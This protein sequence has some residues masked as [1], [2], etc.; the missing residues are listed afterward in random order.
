MF[1][2]CHNRFLLNVYDVETVI[3]THGVSTWHK[4]YGWQWKICDALA[5]PSDSIQLDEL[6]LRQELCEVHIFLLFLL[7]SLAVVVIVVACMLACL[8]GWL[9][10]YFLLSFCSCIF[11]FSW[12]RQR[13][14]EL[15]WVACANTSQHMNTNLNNRTFS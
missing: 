5:I 11:I 10:S 9:A 1:W 3:I 12:F 8:A 14:V 13:W 4:T 7:Q 2:W 6:S 15:S